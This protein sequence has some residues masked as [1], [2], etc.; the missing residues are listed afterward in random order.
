MIV[1]LK[2]WAPWFA[3]R[4]ILSY[5]FSENTFVKKHNPYATCE[6]LIRPK[7]NSYPHFYG[8]VDKGAK[9]LS[10]FTCIFIHLM[11]LAFFNW[12]LY[13]LLYHYPRIGAG[14]D[15]ANMVPWTWNCESSKFIYVPYGHVITGD[16]NTSKDREVKNFFKNDQNIVFHLK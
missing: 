15:P 9:K 5:L 1:Y 3:N 16:L 11:S 2:F 14:W 7:K 12:F 4:I 6:E 13:V 8:N 10:T